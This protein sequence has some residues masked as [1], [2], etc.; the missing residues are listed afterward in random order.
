MY[1]VMS[2]GPV[3]V[4]FLRRVIAD[5]TSC[6]EKGL[7]SGSILWVLWIFLMIFLVLGFCLWMKIEVNCLLNLLAI[8]RGLVWALLL[9]LIGWFGGGLADF[10]ESF[11]INVQN[12][13]RT[14]VP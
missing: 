9:K 6:G 3:A 11:L 14:V 12:L 7:N 8:E 13:R 2:S 5:W 1:P 4:E 10:P